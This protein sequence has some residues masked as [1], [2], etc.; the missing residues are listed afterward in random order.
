MKMIAAMSRNWTSS[1]VI[2][3]VV[4]L[5]LASVVFAPAPAFAQVTLC[6]Q[7]YDKYEGSNWWWGAFGNCKKA[8][9][10]VDPIAI[11]ECAWK[12][13]PPPENITCLKDRLRTSSSTKKGT[14]A[15]IY[16]NSGVPTCDQL[17]AKYEGSSWWWGAFGNCKKHGGET[18]R[19]KI[20]ECAWK[21]APAPENTVCLKEKLRNSPSTKKG[22]DVVV[23][24][25][26][27]PAPKPASTTIAGTCPG[28]QFRQGYEYKGKPGCGSPSEH[29][30]ALL[31][32]DSSGYYCCENAQGATSPR[33]GTNKWEYEPDCT[34]ICA[35]VTGNCFVELLKQ[36]GITYGCYKQV[37]K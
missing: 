12:Q 21:Q 2:G 30:S 33:C 36:G 6:N 34:A 17:Y 7:L 19:A 22:I 28:G 5:M 18:D 32:C 9:G 27:Q 10:T 16:A 11:F 1:L 29:P 31:N 8:H 35:H 14:D 25:N 26:R 20:F 23:D 13:V 4:T 37:V 3:V 24:Y 15:V